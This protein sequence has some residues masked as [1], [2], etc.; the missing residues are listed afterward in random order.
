MGYICRYARRPPIS[1]VRIKN[2]TGDYVTFEYKDYNANGLKT[3][4]TIRT[5]EFIKRIIRHIPPHYFN[6]IRHY[7]L[8]A[9]RVKTWYNKIVNKLLG[10]VKGVNKAKTWQERQFDYHGEDPLICKI[11][12]RIMRF[13][14]ASITTPISRIKKHFQAIFA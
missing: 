7:G 1:E 5:T 6:A 13:V 8:I 3:K 4:L 14:S 11:C 2:Y 10:I 12:G 9:S